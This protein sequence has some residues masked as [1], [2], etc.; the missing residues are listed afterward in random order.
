MPIKPP[1]REITVVSI[2]NCS[3]MCRR[4]APS[5]RR[6]PISFVRS[7]TVASMM[8]M[9]PIPPTTSANAAMQTMMKLN[10]RCVRSAARRI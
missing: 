6:M 5:A 7:V 9:I 2:K 1:D 8:F 3:V 4:F 10:V